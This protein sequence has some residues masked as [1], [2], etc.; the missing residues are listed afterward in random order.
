M[1]PSR[2]SVAIT[3]ASFVL[4]AG[5]SISI[6]SLPDS[7]SSYFAANPIYTTTL[8]SEQP[9]QTINANSPGLNILT[10]PSRCPASCSNTGSNPSDW[11]VY[12]HVSR[13]AQCNET[14][15]LDFA[16]YNPLDNSSSHATIRSCTASFDTS[17]ASD[18]AGSD[19]SCISMGN[20]TQVQESLQMAWLDSSTPGLTIDVIAAV[21]Q[22][23]SY[24]VQ[25]DASCND[26]IAFAY[27]GQATVGLFAGSRIQGQ[28]GILTSLLQ[29]FSAQ[30]ESNGISDSLL[31]QLCSGNG[32]SSRYALGL[33]ANANGDIAF[34]QN[35]VKTWSSGECITTYD[36]QATW[37]N[38]TFLG[39]SAS[40]TLNRTSTNS[41]LAVTH[42]QR[43]L[44]PRATCTTVEAATG[45]SCE[46]SNFG[47][48][49]SQFHSY[50]IQNHSQ[51]RNSSNLL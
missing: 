48:S 15:L 25:Q 43:A 34:V 1:R 40:S 35:A 5:Q 9:K 8:A 6:A 16:I 10:R 23:Q 19:K 37:Q 17:N 26:T 18:S 22:M 14:M 49:F 21:Q 3:I 51:I 44:G 28:Q 50:N 36:G 12:H 13:L 41:T 33:V 7:L 38:I 30:V 27:S 24:L 11:T 42:V 39:P 29:E 46:Y 20:Q 45:D 47:N 32:R 2:F 4:F 31:V